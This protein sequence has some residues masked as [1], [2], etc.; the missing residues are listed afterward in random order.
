MKHDDLE[1]LAQALFEESG[2]ALF[3]F[4]PD[5]FQL[6]DANSMAQRLTGFSL[7]ELLQMSVQQLFRF[8]GQEGLQRMLQASKKTTLFHSQEGYFLRTVQEDIWIPVNLSTARLHVRPKAMGLITARDDR[9]Q[10]QAREK[11]QQ[12]EAELRRVMGSV[13]DCLWSAEIDE[14]G[15][16]IFRYFS[17]VVEKITGQP[18]EYFLPGIHRWWGVVHFEDQPRWAQALGRLRAGQSSQEEYRVVLPDGTHR[19]V[20]DSVMVSQEKNGRLRF[21]GVLRDIHARKQAELALQDKE[22][23]FQAFMDNNPAVAFV[24][25]R[26]G[27]HIYCNKPFQRFFQKGSETVLGKTAFDLFPPDV[28]RQL[29]ESDAAV[30]SSNKAIE[31]IERVPT[32]DGVL[33]DWLIIKFPFADTSGQQLIGGVA[34]EVTDRRHLDEVP[35]SLA[36]GP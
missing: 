21:D 9:Q 24:K 8:Q 18:P 32:A 28:A 3:L 1:G 17:P 19:W 2:D 12:M 10:F 25:D 4:D 20:L 5:T 31:T 30:L 29:Q 16:C 27:R 33:R 23:R 15:Q 26:E 7:R 11:L 35:S 14:A 13:S 6:L 22:A 34:I 36:S